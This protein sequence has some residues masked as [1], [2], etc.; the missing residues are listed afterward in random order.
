[1]EKLFSYFVQIF[2]HV[3]KSFLFCRPHFYFLLK[4]INY[5]SLKEL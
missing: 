4:V 2:M 5:N 3:V 1:M